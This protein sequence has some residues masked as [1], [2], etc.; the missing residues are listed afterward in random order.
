MSYKIFKNVTVSL[1]R[2]LLI[3]LEPKSV[4]CTKHNQP[5]KLLQILVSSLFWRK[6]AKTIFLIFKQLYLCQFALFCTEIDWFYVLPFNSNPVK[7]Q[8]IN[9]LRFK[10]LTKSRFWPSKEE[11]IRSGKNSTKLFICF[12]GLNTLSIHLF[13]TFFISFRH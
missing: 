13:L 8:N 3:P 4:D 5:W 9:L 1:K 2:L 6:M 10:P 7:K 12:G 11:Q